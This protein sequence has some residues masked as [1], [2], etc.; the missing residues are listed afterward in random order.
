[1]EEVQPLCENPGSNDKIEAE[2][3]ANVMVGNND[4]GSQ[5]GDDS[6]WWDSESQNIL[7]TQQLAEALT[8]CEEFL[9]S[10]S[11]GNANDGTSKGKPGLSDYAQLGSEHLKKDLEECQMLVHDPANIELDTPPEFGLSQLVCPVLCH[12]TT[13]SIG[14]I[15]LFIFSIIFDTDA[16]LP[17]SVVGI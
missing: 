3:H 4:N 15:Q 17:C 10:Q 16:S 8:L 14:F 12:F 11:D 1:M 2:N 9:N 7:D 5:A 13:L 6:K